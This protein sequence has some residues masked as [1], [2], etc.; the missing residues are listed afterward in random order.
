MKKKMKDHDAKCRAEG[1]AFVPLVM[2]SFG[3]YNEEARKFLDEKCR[4]A[5][6]LRRQLKTCERVD[7][8]TQQVSFTMWKFKAEAYMARFP[9]GKGGCQVWWRSTPLK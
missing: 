2:E 1:V 8:F 6:Q 3:G 5:V 4:E 9:R 7:M